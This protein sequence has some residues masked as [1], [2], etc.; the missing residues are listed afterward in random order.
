[1]AQVL[2]LYPWQVALSKPCTVNMSA[3]A[4]IGGQQMHG[5]L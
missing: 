1:M 4:V 3:S 5:I 2:K